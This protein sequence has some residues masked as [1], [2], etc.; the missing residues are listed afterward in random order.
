MKNKAIFLDRDGV[1]NEDAGYVH[2]IEDFKIIPGVFNS[3]KKLQS[4][5]YKLIVI[6]NQSGI[7]RGIYTMEDF[8]KVNKYMMNIL[9]NQGIK[10]D[11]VY[12]CPHNPEDNCNCRKPKTGLLEKAA[13]EFDIDIESSWIIGDKLSDVEMGE[14]AGCKTLLLESKYVRNIKRFKLKSLGEVS[15]YILELL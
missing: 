7:G 2:R 15:D 12:F 13:E 5:G 14:K 4:A 6:T 1:I 8:F 9:K 10:I 11:K 3:L